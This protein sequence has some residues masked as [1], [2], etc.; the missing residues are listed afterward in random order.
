MTGSTL[1]LNEHSLLFLR[2][3]SYLELPNHQHHFHITYRLIQGVFRGKLNAILL[4]NIIELALALV[5]IMSGPHT[6]HNWYKF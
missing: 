3:S 6:K 4:K 2:F 5:T 1:A